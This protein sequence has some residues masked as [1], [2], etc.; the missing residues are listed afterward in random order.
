MSQGIMNVTIEESEEKDKEN[1]SPVEKSSEEST[2]QFSQNSGFGLN[3]SQ[4]LERTWVTDGIRK[5]SQDLTPIE[6]TKDEKRENEKQRFRVSTLNFKKANIVINEQ[7]QA[8]EVDYEV[9][10]KIRK[11]L[12]DHKKCK[13]LK[14]SEFDKLMMILGS[15]KIDEIVLGWHSA[16]S[17]D[18]VPTKSKSGSNLKQFLEKF[19]NANKS[20]NVKLD[21]D[22]N[23]S[24]EDLTWAKR[25]LFFAQIVKS[26]NCLLINRD[27]RKSEF[28]DSPVFGHTLEL[29]MLQQVLLEIHQA[30]VNGKVIP[31]KLINSRKNENRIPHYVKTKSVLKGRIDTTPVAG[32]FKLGNIVNIVD[33]L[34]T[35][36]G[37]W[38][39]EFKTIL[40]EVQAKQIDKEMKKEAMEIDTRI[41]NILEIVFMCLVKMVSC[42][43]I[44]MY[45]DY[46]VKHHLMGVKAATLNM[47]FEQND[48]LKMF[49]N[50]VR[51]KYG[52]I[53]DIDS[54][55]K[56]LL[57]K[58]FDYG[59]RWNSMTKFLME[60]HVIGKLS[61]ETTK[62]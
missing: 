22:L 62:N 30:F 15:Y 55:R 16:Y 17:G 35:D 33:T 51:I 57:T 10:R 38:N 46:V 59:S 48:K 39:R 41:A 58:S 18:L 53:K 2:Q 29:L 28:S 52:E 8:V 54:G 32:E 9:E 13:N 20:K 31:K 6:L 26:G 56:E 34:I 49:F 3:E 24:D 5:D 50:N 14:I 21:K 60:A 19:E 11:L 12:A 43:Y 7:F 47:R 36:I 4:N 1:K 40:A 37:D 42:L 27:E 61:K 25:I 45:D 44:C 23:G